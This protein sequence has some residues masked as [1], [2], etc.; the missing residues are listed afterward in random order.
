MPASGVSN[1]STVGGEPSSAASHVGAT[2]STPHSLNTGTMSGFQTPSRSTRRR[3]SS[4]WGLGLATPGSGRDRD[5]LFG[6]GYQSTDVSGSGYS[7]GGVP[8]LVFSSGGG[9][10]AVLDDFP[11]AHWGNASPSR[12]ASARRR[13][14]SGVDPLSVGGGRSLG[15]RPSTSSLRSSATRHRTSSGR[16]EK[17]HFDDERVYDEDDDNLG[18][19]TENEQDPPTSSSPYPRTPSMDLGYGSANRLMGVRHGQGSVS[20]SGARS[21]GGASGRPPSTPGSPTP[22]R[23]RLASLG[24]R[25]SLTAGGFAPLDGFSKHGGNGSPKHSTTTRGGHNRSSSPGSMGLHHAQHDPATHFGL[26]LDLDD[27]LNFF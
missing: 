9:I 21:G 15:S 1:S 25:K 5:M 17:V 2:P 27:V 10:D 22:T 24:S 19:D 11:T 16:G 4:G 8:S 14:R 7:T 26:G 23:G 20:G 6:G 13:Q 3:E 12:I 18:L